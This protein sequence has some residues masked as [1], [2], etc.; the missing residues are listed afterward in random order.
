VESDQA[1]TLSPTV[2]VRLYQGAALLRDELLAAGGSRVPTAA[3][4]DVMTDT[5]NLPLGAADVVEGLEVV[6][7]VDPNDLVSEP[8][9]T[10]NVYSGSLP[11]GVLAPLNLVVFPIEASVHGTVGNVGSGDV[12]SL[13]ESAWKWIPSASMTFDVRDPLVTDEDLSTDAGWSNLLG[14]LQAIRTAEGATDQYYHGIIGAFNGIRYGGLGYLP[15]SPGSSF[16]SALSYDRLPFARATV[17]HELGHNLGR[18]HAPCG[19]PASPEPAFPYSDG[20]VGYPGYDVV[21]GSLVS[22]ETY[23]FMS[24]CSPEW[25]SDYAFG[26]MVS[27]RSD[28]PR[29]ATAYPAADGAATEGLLVWGRVGPNGVTLNPGFVVTAPPRLPESSQGSN[30]VRGLASDGRELFRITFEGVPLSEGPGSDER[31]FAFLVPLDAAQAADLSSIDL[32][33]PFGRAE[34]TAGR[35]PAAPA[36]A[37]VLRGPGGRARVQWDR[38]AFAAA[39]LR[40]RSTGRILGIVRG[41]DV[42]FG[43]GRRGLDQIEVLLSDGVRTVR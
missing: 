43:P 39:L 30:T 40:D 38:D 23:D 1:N 31:H 6:V 34:R 41:G 13:F 10:D 20:S 42:S 28:D 24:Y 16:R 15:S 36:P 11:V 29:V 4:L 35:A 3:D 14:D 7:E 32:D 12:A 25:T 8:D 22:S 9:E 5:W 18:P 19:G 27:W 2:R 37:T 21:T 17:A 26:Q 33:S